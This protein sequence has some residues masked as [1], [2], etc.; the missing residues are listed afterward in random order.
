MA[1][2][3]GALEPPWAPDLGP[4]SAGSPL[5]NVGACPGWCTQL[6]GARAPWNQREGHRGTCPQGLPGL[7][8]EVKGPVAR[9]RQRERALLQ[10]PVTLRRGFWKPPRRGSRGQEPCQGAALLQTPAEPP[11]SQPSLP[12]PGPHA[13]VQLPASA[14]SATVLWCQAHSRRCVTVMP[15]THRTLS[16]HK[17]SSVPA[18]HQLPGC[19]P[20][21]PS[22]SVWWVAILLVCSLGL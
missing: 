19:G 7:I 2:R 12:S 11:L 15:S 9:T 18:R 13:H 4:V 20:G 16:S 17:T 10:V 5:P 21:T 8:T 14:F 22:T 6:P 1:C 3:S